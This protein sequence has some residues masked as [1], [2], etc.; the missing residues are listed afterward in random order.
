MATNLTCKKCGPLT[1][2]D[3]AVVTDY[4]QAAGTITS[5]RQCLQCD[6]P[7]RRVA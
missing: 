5:S 1:A 6:G 3:V 7:V 2:P 4:D